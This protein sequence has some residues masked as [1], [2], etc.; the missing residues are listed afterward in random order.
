MNTILQ[1]VRY[2]LRMMRKNRGL[3]FVVVLS[4]AIGIGANSAV[5]S[6]VDALLLRPLPYPQLDRLANIW[7]HSPGIGIYRDWPSPG[8]YQ[9][10]QQENHSF[11]EMAIANLDKITLT[12]HGQPQRIDIMKAS[13]S[14]FRLLGGKPL[15]GRLFLA[16]E[17][18]PGRPPVVILTFGI[19]RRLFGA[20]PGIVGKSVVLDGVT[21]VV[22]G[23]LD[24][25]FH[26]N[27]EVMPAEMRMG[28]VD[29]FLPLAI[30]PGRPNFRDDENYNVLARLKPG[31]SLQQAQADVDAIASRIREKDHRDRTFGMSVV[32]LQD[33][34]VGDVRRTLLVMLGA[35]AL[36]LLIACANVGNL[37]LASA[38]ARRREI[39]IRAALGVGGWRIVR[40]L[41]TESALL[42]VMGGAAGGLLAQWAL[43]ALRALNPGN[44]PRLEEIHINL[45]VLAFT[46]AVSILTG[47][48][49]GVAPAWR[50][51]KVDVSEALKA[52]GRGASGDSGLRLRGNQLRGLLV[53]SELALSLVLL[54]GAG[55]LVRSLMRLQEVPA[56]FN[57]DPIVTM[58][59]SVHGAQSRQEIPLF[60]KKIGQFHWEIADRI[61][62]LPG[63]KDVGMVS[64]LPL[65]G[66]VGW[67]QIH[68]EGYTPPPGEE[69]QT[70]YRTVSAD[71]FSTMGIPLLKGRFFTDRDIGRSSMVAIVDERFAARF[72]P[73]GDAIGKHL[74]DAV[75]EKAMTIV[76]VVGTVKQD[77]LD[78]QGKPAMYISDQQDDTEDTYLVV[79]EKA[80][81]SGDAAGLT[82]G[83]ER[84]IHAVDADA[85]VYDAR[86]MRDRWRD[87]LARPRFS[88]SVL[89]AFA[90][91][92]VLLAAIGVFGV[93]SYLVSRS[94][95]D[96]G[97]YMALG[98]R[99]ASILAMVVEQGL[100]LTVTG[101]G[102]GLVGAVLLSGAMQSLLFGVKATDTVT[103][104]SMAA[105]LTVVALLATIIPALRAVRVDPMTALREE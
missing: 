7:L 90:A 80:N 8:E 81:F 85:V 40:Q 79:R 9:D 96:I 84:E 11:D 60:V 51:R 39:A 104:A 65:T 71:Y 35:V 31:V 37:L 2:A 101:V 47:L 49:F 83:I 1:D 29:V 59:V 89:G 24:E 94:K 75:P 42:G 56:G 82:R 95:H 98:A 18:N 66:T 26:V 10:L 105:I 44:I 43:G 102:V 6:V 74:W 92:A 41:L 57:L 23:V 52:G 14:L 103:F 63:V 19:W 21:R 73:G 61:K 64:A 70:D 45:A 50:A 13:S 15:L 86:T 25:S 16:D 68:V 33:Q 76:G 93:F 28:T 48:I 17:D 32:G 46:A 100:K 20:D 69:F 34:V 54:T 72:W 36:V 55:L 53:V 67:G 78:I 30:D 77:G 58:K 87:A 22:A 5:F 12:G 99:P 38:A 88:A 4:L 91:F 3:T 97:V 62:N 27:A